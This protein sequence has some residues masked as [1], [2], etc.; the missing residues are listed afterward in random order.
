MKRGTNTKIPTIKM[1]QIHYFADI[2]TTIQIYSPVASAIR[3][4]I[5]IT[6]VPM[7]IICCAARK[8]W[9]PLFWHFTTWGNGSECFHLSDQVYHNF[10]QIND[11]GL[12]WMYSFIF[13]NLKTLSVNWFNKGNFSNIAE[14]SPFRE[15][16]LSATWMMLFKNAK[17]R[18]I[19]PKNLRMLAPAQ[20]LKRDLQ[21]EPLCKMATVRHSSPKC[22]VIGQTTCSRQKNSI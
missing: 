10:H 22:V 20:R 11:C 3:A 12:C 2:V 16:R 1:L 7:S 6:R 17:G 21:R 15:W 13:G 4:I 5:R 19:Q 18:K 8:C 14:W 9:L